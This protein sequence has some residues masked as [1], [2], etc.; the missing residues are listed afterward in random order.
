MQIYLFFRR[1]RNLLHHSKLGIGHLSA[2][3]RLNILSS[4]P[5]FIIS[6]RAGLAK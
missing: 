6:L 5:Q 1:R 4:N 2:Y 3:G